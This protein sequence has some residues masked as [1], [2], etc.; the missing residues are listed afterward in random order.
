MT[1]MLRPVFRN[2]KSSLRKQ[3][4]QSSTQTPAMRR[5]SARQKKLLLSL[6]GIG[7]SG[8]SDISAAHDAYLNET[9]QRGKRFQAPFPSSRVEQRRPRGEESDRWP[10]N[11]LIQTA[12]DDDLKAALEQNLPCS[13]GLGRASV[14][15]RRFRQ[16]W[17]AC[18]NRII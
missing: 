10:V 3:K 18:L 12:Y 15:T 5:L 4:Q 1:A 17:T 16:K 2:G 7:S 9:R 11:R 13:N 6:A 8:L 14:R